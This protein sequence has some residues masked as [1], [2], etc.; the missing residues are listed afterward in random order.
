MIGTSDQLTAGQSLH[1]LHLFGSVIAARRTFRCW[2]TCQH[3]PR[4]LCCVVETAKTTSRRNQKM[5]ES[6]FSSPDLSTD[7]FYTCAQNALGCCLWCT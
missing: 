7:L 2:Q 6:Q 4:R 1:T 5:P 3:D